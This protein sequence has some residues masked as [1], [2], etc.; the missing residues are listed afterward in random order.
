MESEQAPAGI[1]LTDSGMPQSPDNKYYGTQ[2][3]MRFALAKQTIL[4]MA[5]T[6]QQHELKHNEQLT[7]KVHA[8]FKS[9]IRDMAKCTHTLGT[10]GKSGR[11]KTATLKE[12][13]TDPNTKT[14]D[15]EKTKEY[16][17]VTQES[18]TQQRT[19][20]TC[21]VSELDNPSLSSFVIEYNR[22]CDFEATTSRAKGSGESAVG[23]L[24]K[25]FCRPHQGFWIYK[26]TAFDVDTN[27]HT[28]Q[29]TGEAHQPEKVCFDDR[30][31]FVAEDIPWEEPQIVMANAFDIDNYET[32]NDTSAPPIRKGDVRA[33]WFPVDR[34]GRDFEQQAKYFFDLNENENQNGERATLNHVRDVIAEE[35][36]TAG[37]TTFQ[38]ARIA[39]ASRPSC[40]L[41][42]DSQE[43][44]SQSFKR[45]QRYAGNETDE[46]DELGSLSEKDYDKVNDTVEFEQTFNRKRACTTFSIDSEGEIQIEQVKLHTRFSYVL[47]KCLVYTPNTGNFAT[48]VLSVAKFHNYW[49]RKE[50]TGP[51]IGISSLQL[52]ISTLKHGLAII[53]FPG[54]SKLTSI[55]DTV[56]Q[57]TL[58]LS[59]AAVMLH[60]ADNKQMLED[61]RESLRKYITAMLKTNPD[62]MLQRTSHG[63]PL[64]TAG[65]TEDRSVSVAGAGAALKADSHTVQNLRLA[66]V[67][68]GEKTWPNSG[69][70]AH[71]QHCSHQAKQ[72][73]EDNCERLKLEANEKNAKELVHKQLRKI[74][75]DRAHQASARQRLQL[76]DR[77]MFVD[78]FLE[79][80][81]ARVLISVVYPKME[82]MS[83]LTSQASN[84]EELRN[85]IFQE[86]LHGRP[87]MLQRLILLNLQRATSFQDSIRDVFQLNVALGNCDDPMLQEALHGLQPSS[88]EV[89][90]ELSTWKNTKLKGYAEEWKQKVHEQAR[91]VVK[92]YHAKCSPDKYLET[93]SVQIF[94]NLPE[95][96]RKSLSKPY[97]LE[98]FA[99][100]EKCLEFFNEKPVKFLLRNLF[101]SSNSK[102]KSNEIFGMGLSML[103]TYPLM[104]TLK[105]ASFEQ[106]L[107][108]QLDYLQDTGLEDTNQE[109]SSSPVEHILSDL[110][111]IFALGKSRIERKK[112]TVVLVLVFYQKC[113]EVIDH[114]LLCIKM[115]L[116][117]DALE[118]VSRLYSG[119]WLDTFKKVT[120][121]LVDNKKLKDI[122]D[123]HKGMS[124]KAIDAQH[125]S[126]EV[127][128]YMRDQYC[129]K[130]AERVNELIDLL[131]S[132]LST[133]IDE[134]CEGLNTLTIDDLKETLNHQAMLPGA[135]ED[136]LVMEQQ[137]V[138]LRCISQH[139]RFSADPVGDSRVAA[140]VKSL[141]DIEKLSLIIPLPKQD[142]AKVLKENLPPDGV[143][144]Y[145]QRNFPG[146]HGFLIAELVKAMQDKDHGIVFDDRDALV[147]ALT[148]QGL[149]N[150]EATT[151]E[152]RVPA[153]VCEVITDELKKQL[154]KLDDKQKEA[155]GL[156]KGILLAI[157]KRLRRD[158]PTELSEITSHLSADQ[159]NVKL[160]YIVETMRA[161]FGRSSENVHSK[162]WLLRAQNRLK[163]AQIQNYLP[164]GWKAKYLPKQAVFRYMYQGSA[165]TF[166]QMRQKAASQAK[167]A[168]TDFDKQSKMEL[169][170][171]CQQRGI[172]HGNKS[173]NELITLLRD[174][175]KRAADDAALEKMRRDASRIVLQ[176][177]MNPRA[178]PTGNTVE[179]AH[180]LRDLKNV[181]FYE[182]MM[183][184]DVDDGYRR[185]L[186]KGRVMDFDIKDPSHVAL[187][188]KENEEWIKDIPLTYAQPVVYYEL[189]DGTKWAECYT[190]LDQD[191]FRNKED[192]MNTGQG[193]AQGPTVLEEDGQGTPSKR[194]KRPPSRYTYHQ[195]GGEPGQQKT[196]QAKN[197]S[198]IDVTDNKDDSLGGGDTT[199][200]EQRF[201]N[202]PHLDVD[203]N[204]GEATIMHGP[205][206]IQELWQLRG[207]THFRLDLVE[208]DCWIY[209]S[210]EEREEMKTRHPER[211]EDKAYFSIGAYDAGTKIFT[212]YSA[213]PTSH[214]TIRPTP[215]PGASEYPQHM[216]SSA[217]TSAGLRTEQHE[218][219]RMS[220][221]Y[222][223]FRRH[224]CWSPQAYSPKSSSN[225]TISAQALY[226]K[227]VRRSHIR[228][229]H[230]AC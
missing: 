48:D 97:T 94:D 134:F 119:V 208:D 58:N 51:Q 207:R 3:A 35:G 120:D 219:G 38:A 129:E 190:Y 187:M 103:M 199:C 57:G 226:S 8:A 148:A 32:E 180:D 197:A 223:L 155:T 89:V 66:C 140:D 98:T 11:G 54:N 99:Q 174:Y 31:E 222:A 5:N 173:K 105:E 170:N 29:P 62:F 115:R 69:Q 30:S 220:P 144:D 53:D 182:K 127:A 122:C 100:K 6:S 124:D 20:R 24:V 118:H 88:L 133:Y 1:M 106:P 85:F 73:A 93:L 9:D 135:V 185:G 114:F 177:K 121:Y 34:D 162:D 96:R 205:G 95:D 84:M 117:C 186:A 75:R 90:G 128:D 37:D 70:Y 188:R 169:R 16:D 196:G 150:G 216:P 113:K 102:R 108:L 26:V 45:L 44:V 195:F 47:G 213:R 91:E 15:W 179:C 206:E 101:S 55:S 151:F 178:L 154:D 72:Y 12:V 167:V 43:T 211:Q 228:N 14:F 218:H 217:A 153:F 23:K 77:H 165:H 161:C 138:V 10:D 40:T 181:N 227:Y 225:G 56:R 230:I 59:H 149:D 68:L 159:I 194:E 83:E 158:A 157:C 172:G 132:D 92:V 21:D 65:A 141:E 50:N 7:K 112:G 67:I 52:P 71:G 49:T 39:F 192:G 184:P 229:I 4:C 125:I 107:F 210:R 76:T 146:I 36:N 82:S 130:Y 204:H 152:F 42:F 79:F 139:Q 202:Q 19:L 116:S 166:H 143:E 63:R 78:K 164:A 110:K 60:V 25:H 156:D 198:R 17:T 126:Q 214:N 212:P 74:V 203:G 171:E 201:Q 142:I 2:D 111:K 191:D 160:R 22:H 176:D 221:A 104:K 61:D 28:L 109:S 41:F 64:S 168:D 136:F 215:A 224:I 87:E 27:T 189:P 209:T 137:K 145:C 200:P 13:L 193:A 18:T 131:I 33:D 81:E 175:D 183:A 86:V 46:D 123:I 163:E 80:F 147:K